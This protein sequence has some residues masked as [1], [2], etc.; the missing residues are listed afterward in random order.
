[1]L[2]GWIRVSFSARSTLARRA[3]G[4]AAGLRLGVGH[5]GSLGGRHGRCS[6]RGN[7]GECQNVGDNRDRV[8]NK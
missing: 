4:G 7:K 1:M 5:R 2:G 6:A 8:V 3:I